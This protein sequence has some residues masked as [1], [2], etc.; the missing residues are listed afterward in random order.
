VTSAYKRRFGFCLTHRQRE[1]LVPGTYRAVIDSMTE[2]AG[3]MD[4]LVLLSSY[5]CH[6]SLANNELSGPLVLLGLHDW[7]RAWGRRR[8]TYRF[9][10]NPETI[11][12][13]CYL[14]QH[15]PGLQA[16]LDYGLVLTC[17]SGPDTSLSY[18]RSRPGDSL[19]D[20]LIAH[21]HRVE[22]ERWRVREFDPTSGSD[23]RQYGSPGFKLPM[24]QMAHSVY[25]DYPECH[26]SG[27][28]KELMDTA[29]LVRTVDQLE[30][31][32][33]LA[34]DCGIYLN[35]QPYGE[36]QLGPRGLYPDINTPNLWDKLGLDARRT[37]DRIR[38]VLNYADGEH[39]LIQ[40]AELAGCSV[41]DLV[42]IAGMLERHD[43]LERDAPIQL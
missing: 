10:L 13:L 31:L 37:L 18:K 21:L 3:D 27:D 2:L 38:Y 7:I 19:L 36:P 6:P 11:G 42:P 39:D 17:V 15:G 5:L 35:Q 20:R 16:R 12:S 25:G 23:E 24:A 40:I 9:L 8:K 28:T 1:A 41:R 26:T 22:P 29:Q 33:L 32:L 30:P 43:L 14:F 4:E 34:E